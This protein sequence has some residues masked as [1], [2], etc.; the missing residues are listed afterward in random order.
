MNP[1]M[2]HD[3][4]HELIHW[5]AAAVL[6]AGGSI[7]LALA[8]YGRFGPGSRVSGPGSGPRDD[9]PVAG[10]GQPVDR[11]LVW[12][13]ASLSIGAAAIHLAA[14]PHHYAELGDLGAGFLFAGIFQALWARAFLRSTTR[15]TAWIGFVVNTGIVGAWIYSRVVGLPVGPEPWTPEAI[16]LPDA[17]STI[18]EVLVLVGLTVRLL[19]VDRTAIATRARVRSIAAIAVVPALGLVLLTSSLATVAIAAGVDHGSTHVSLSGG[20]EHAMTGR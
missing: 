15:R 2:S 13:V 12:I 19:G 9:R 1:V 7:F 16:G 17:A 5:I 6:V 11:S 4:A 18:F 10:S 14:A 3:A 8:A 20:A